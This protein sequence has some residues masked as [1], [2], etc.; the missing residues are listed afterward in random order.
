[1]SSQLFDHPKSESLVTDAHQHI[2]TRIRKLRQDQKLTLVNLA[3]KCGISPSFLSQIERDQASPSVTTLYALAD[4]LGEP[5]ASL[6]FNHT[7]PN[8]TPAPPSVQTNLKILRKDQ[9]K[10]IIYPDF[11]ILNELLSPSPNPRLQLIRVVMPPGASSGEQPFVHAG[12]ECGIVLQGRLE[13]TIGGETYILNPGDSIYHSS[14]LPHSS[15]NIGTEDL[16]MI[17][18]KTSPSN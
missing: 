8:G 18:A 14:R 3:E 6:F 7:S 2:G 11:G 16:I 5:V 12:E 1:M 9:R 17:V 4:A 15:R 13:T 10:K